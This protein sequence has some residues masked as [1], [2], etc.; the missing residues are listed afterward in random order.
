MHGKPA[1]IKIASAFAC[2]AS[3]TN[4]FAHSSS[5]SLTS[6]NKVSSMLFLEANVLAKSQLS[7]AWQSTN[8]RFF[9]FLTATWQVLSP[10]NNS[11]NATLCTCLASL[12]PSW[13][14]WK[15]LKLFTFPPALGLSSSKVT[16]R[17]FV[18]SALC[19]S[20]A[21]GRGGLIAGRRFSAGLWPSFD[22]KSVWP[23]QGAVSIFLATVEDRKSSDLFGAS[24]SV[25][26]IVFPVWLHAA[27]ASLLHTFLG[28][29]RMLQR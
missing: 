28:A 8:F 20:G 5:R 17:F 4:F 29:T 21:W 9:T 6:L 22:R 10:A 11:S 18:S 3:A 15:R 16:L 2:S 14:F 19:S 23:F 26:E 13:R 24:S 25:Q 7:A 27:W 1:L 12:L